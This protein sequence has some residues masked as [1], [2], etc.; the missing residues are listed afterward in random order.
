MKY[1]AMTQNPFKDLSIQEKEDVFM[2]LFSMGTN[3]NNSID[4][5]FELLYLICFLSFKMK[6]RDPEKFGS[7]LNVLQ[8]LYGRSFS[9]QTGEDS[10]LISLGILCKELLYG[11]DEIKKPEGFTNIGEICARIKDLV[12]QWMPF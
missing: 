6:E 7:P 2:Q 8:Q 1:M 4:D 5:K 3:T 10:Y 9:N 11:V 12:S